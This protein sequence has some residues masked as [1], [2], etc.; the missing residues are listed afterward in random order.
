V[1]AQIDPETGFLASPGCPRTVTEVFIAGTAPTQTCPSHGAI[2]SSEL[3]I[4]N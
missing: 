4:E 2:Q 3:R 1:T